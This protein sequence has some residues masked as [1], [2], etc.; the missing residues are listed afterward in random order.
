MKFKKGDL[1]KI[2]YVKGQNLTNTPFEVGNI[3]KILNCYNNS[4]Y[5][6]VE[7]DYMIDADDWWFEENE[8]EF[9][10]HQK[11]LNRKYGY[12]V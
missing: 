5:P 2:I 8:L 12:E 10:S 11:R 1:V 9:I 4:R 7:N 3:V 6:W